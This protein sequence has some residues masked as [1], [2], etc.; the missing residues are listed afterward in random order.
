MIRGL[1]PKTVILA[2]GPQW[3]RN[4]SGAAKNPVKG[5]NIVYSAHCYPPHLRDFENN[6]GP[7]FDKFPVFFSEW[8]YEKGAEFPAS[9][10]TAGFGAPFKKLIE[11]RG[12]SWAAWCFD[13]DW[14]PKIFDKPWSLPKDDKAR[15]GIFVK[16]WLKENMI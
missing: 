5:G 14:F 15:M 6:W 7:L 4:M 9:G 13:N 3:C 16:E 11:D 12:C 10:T 2:G 8:G 1:A